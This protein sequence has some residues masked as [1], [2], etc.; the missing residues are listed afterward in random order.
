MAAD[1]PVVPDARMSAPEIR[2]RSSI[3]DRL[4]IGFVVHASATVHVIAVVKLSVIVWNRSVDIKKRLLRSKHTKR[5]LEL[6]RISA[7]MPLVPYLLVDVSRTIQLRG[8]HVNP[9][10]CPGLK[11]GVRN[12]GTIRRPRP[13]PFSALR[14]GPVFYVGTAVKARRMRARTTLFMR[15]LL[16]IQHDR[17]P[18]K[19]RGSTDDRYIAVGPSLWRRTNWTN[20]RRW[21]LVNDKF[22][23]GTTRR[24]ELIT[25]GHLRC[26]A[27]TETL[28]TP[29]DRTV[30]CRA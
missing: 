25:T 12:V 14:H 9:F 17:H 28:F 21:Q 23:R 18:A 16:T 3:P 8:R 24:V 15:S 22:V 11:L 27:T 20:I 29:R 4:Y 6:S 7:L 19:T 13:S 10:D 30:Y 2:R 5:I 26:L 1:L